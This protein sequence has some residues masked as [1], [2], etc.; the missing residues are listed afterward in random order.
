MMIAHA[1]LLILDYVEAE[2]PPWLQLAPAG[3]RSALLHAPPGI[4]QVLVEAGLAYRDDSNTV[5]FWDSIAARARG[6]TD[7]SLSA[8]GRM[9]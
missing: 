4:Q 3:R 8:I 7:A 6:M 5:L 2:N 1:C 9:G